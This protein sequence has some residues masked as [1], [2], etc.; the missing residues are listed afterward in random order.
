ML[1]VHITD[2]SYRQL[3]MMPLSVLE[4]LMADERGSLY[5]LSGSGGGD[6][7]FGEVRAGTDRMLVNEVKRGRI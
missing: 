3:V 1:I 7:G 4:R 5:A 6:I 2:R